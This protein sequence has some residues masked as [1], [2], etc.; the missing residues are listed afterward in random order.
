M[1]DFIDKRTNDMVNEY[2]AAIDALQ[3]VL[4]GRGQV[5]EFENEDTKELFIKYYAKTKEAAD[6][7]VVIPGGAVC[8]RATN[9]RN[10]ITIEPKASLCV[11]NEY[12]NNV[13][14]S[15]HDSIAEAE[16]ARLQFIHDYC[17][18]EEG[19]EL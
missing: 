13:V 11:K 7:L 9:S 3:G 14:I 2:A 8:Y 15:L 18:E 6:R 1:I 16:A 5:H 10:K 4:K 17:K 12:D 19:F